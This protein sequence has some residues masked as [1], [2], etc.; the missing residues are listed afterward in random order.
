MDAKTLALDPKT[1][2][3]LVDTAEFEAAAS[4]GKAGRGPRAKPETFHLLIY[5]K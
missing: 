2:G 5:G 1:H 3:L 4:A